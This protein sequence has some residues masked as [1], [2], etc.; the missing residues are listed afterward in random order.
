[1]PTQGSWHTMDQ[2]KSEMMRRTNPSERQIRCAAWLALVCLLAAAAGL[3]AMHAEAELATTS[4][5][6]HQLYLPSI[7]SPHR[8]YLSL[9]CAP[10]SGGGGEA[11][12]QRVSANPLPLD[13]G[14]ALGLVTRYGENLQLNGQPYTFV[15]TNVSYLAGPYFPQEKMEEAISFLAVSGVQAIRVWVE[16]WC[17]LGRVERMLDLGRK[18]DVRF[19]LTLQDFFGQQ[20]G[21]WFKAKYKT[22]DL[23]HIRRIVP[24]FADRPEVLMWELMNEPTCPAEDADRACWDALYHWAQVTSQEVKRLDPCHLVSVG[25]QRAGFDE[26]AIDTFRRLHALDT[27]DIVSVHAQGG[28]VAKGERQLE[29]DIAHELGKPIFFGEVGLRGH[30]KQCQPLSAKVLQQRAQA[31]AEDIQQ[32][33]EAGID[34]YL[35]WQY[36]C[37][38]VDTGSHIEYFCGVFD[39]FADDPVWEV[40]RAATSE[41]P[42]F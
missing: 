18:Y 6:V 25:T 29:R 33:R 16:P 9:F 11:R 39:Y 26:R 31:I 4:R 14:A 21:W 3:P 35:L 37:G 13:A 7:R 28:K 34:G 5:Q 30:D 42:R 27:I 22:K 2:Q 20:D 12:T 32:S 17:D 24:R 41:R 23:P 36:A 15:G 19:I 10:G 38:A 40:T 1:M 8:L